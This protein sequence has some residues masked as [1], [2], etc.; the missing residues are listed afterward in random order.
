[1]YFRGRGISGSG[2]SEGSLDVPPEKQDAK[3][4][5]VTNRGAAYVP[6][7]NSGSG[8]LLYLRDGI[9]MA[10][11]LDPDS[12]SVSGDAV[13]LTTERVAVF[14]NYGQF[15]ASSTGP[16]VYRAVAPPDSQLTW[17]DPQGKVVGTLGAPESYGSLA[18]SPDGTRALVSK[19]T[20]A[21]PREGVW[22]LDLARG[23]STRTEL[24]PSI[25]NRHGVWSPDG[26]RMVFGSIRAGR[27]MDL[28]EKSVGGADETR[29]LLKSN[30][31]KV[32]LSWSPDGRFVLYGTVGTGDDLWVVPLNNRKPTP[33]LQT[34]LRE[35]DGAFS[36]DGRWVAYVSDESGRPEVYVRAFATDSSGLALPAGGDK[37]IVSTGGGFHPVWGARGTALYYANADGMLVAADVTTGAVFTVNATRTLFKLLTPG[38]EATIDFAPTADGKRFLALVPQAQRE[39]TFRVVLNWPSLIR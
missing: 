31:W 12:L 20:P 19:V 37:T 18:V 32:P 26:T 3:V 14:L 16:L 30:E 13:R 35:S 22:V 17:F 28:Y 38:R 34:P 21:A 23:T 29:V 24:D 1:L 9:L 2:I 8:R 39:S 5:T 33:F 36:P 6:S 11:A 7:S 27:M 25:N 15:S 10:Q 4:L